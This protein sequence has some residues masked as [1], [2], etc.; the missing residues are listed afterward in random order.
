MIRKIQRH[1]FEVWGQEEA[2][3]KFL[4]YLL[5]VVSSLTVVLLMVVC[6]L[7]LKK[8][9]VILLDSETSA[10]L[11][12][13][14]PDG[15]AL[16]RELIR[17]LKKYLTTRHNWDWLTIETKSKEAANYVASDFREKYFL[18]TQ[19]QIRLAKEKQ[20][21]QRLFPDD[22]DIDLKRK[23]A[24]IKAERVL[25]ING[26]RAGQA[27]TFELAFAFGERTPQNPEGIYIT[28]EKL[29]SKHGG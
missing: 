20:V 10:I 22:P 9:P 21:S 24:V 13:S 23:I 1:W 7:A 16:E 4:K 29:D 5:L 28:S 26:I 27:M 2:Q 11:F 12:P 3:N 19:E 15:K 14:A 25:I 18:N 6:V 8:T 17:V